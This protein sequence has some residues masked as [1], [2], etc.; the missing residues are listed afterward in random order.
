VLHLIPFNP[1]GSPLALGWDLMGRKPIWDGR[2]NKIVVFCYCGL[3]KRKW[4]KL[5]TRYRTVC[6]VRYMRIPVR[7]ISPMRNRI[8]FFFMDLC[9]F[10]SPF[11][12]RYDPLGSLVFFAYLSVFTA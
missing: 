5:C 9:S 12:L 1:Q 7:E 6:V 4:G 2:N 11:W 10:V 3:L 8:S